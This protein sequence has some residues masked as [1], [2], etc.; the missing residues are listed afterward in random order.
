M[1]TNREKEFQRI[2]RGDSDEED[3]ETRPA[4]VRDDSYVEARSLLGSRKTTHISSPSQYESRSS[5]S[6]RGRVAAAAAAAV[7]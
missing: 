2:N 6:S 1:L 7:G 4:R 5:S 3:E